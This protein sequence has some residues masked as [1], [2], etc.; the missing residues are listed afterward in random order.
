MMKR[1]LKLWQ[2]VK[3]KKNKIE[4]YRLL[5]KIGMVYSKKQMAEINDAFE[6]DWPWTDNAPPIK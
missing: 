5:Q 1:P 4:F 6:S 3:A 2:Y